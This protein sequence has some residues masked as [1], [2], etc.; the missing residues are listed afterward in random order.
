MKPEDILEHCLEEIAAGRKTAAEC[1][2]L[3]PN[4]PDLEAQLLAAAALKRLEVITLRPEV[5]RR[6]EA[7]LRQKMSV[8]K[9]QATR[10]R[11]PIPLLR[12]AAPFALIT[13]LLFGMVGTVAASSESLPGNPLY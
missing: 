1:A 6:I 10:W 2:A 13:T 9:P 7:R 5:S 8:R 3:F 4:V 11:I 12:W